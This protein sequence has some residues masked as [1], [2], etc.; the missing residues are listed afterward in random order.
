MVAPCSEHFVDGMP[1][2]EH[3]YPSMK[4]A[5][6]PPSKKTRQYL[7]RP[8]APVNDW[9]SIAETDDQISTAGSPNAIVNE[10]DPVKFEGEHS[11][12]VG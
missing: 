8:E 7:V 10:T 1:T 12:N 5:W 2:D 6:E 3:P 9:P 4:L 11:Y